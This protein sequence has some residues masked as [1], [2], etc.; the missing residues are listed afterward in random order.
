M[1]GMQDEAFI[2]A[3]NEG[4]ATRSRPDLISLMDRP[5]REGMG[6]KGRIDDGTAERRVA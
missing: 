6:G 2:R 1:L 4:K 3:K 5:T